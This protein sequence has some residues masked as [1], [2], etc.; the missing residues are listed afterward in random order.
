MKT[1]ESS[2]REKKKKLL[3]LLIGNERNDFIEGKKCF[4]RKDVSMENGG[5]MP[6]HTEVYVVETSSTDI[7]VIPTMLTDSQNPYDNSAW[8]KKNLLLPFTVYKEV[9][10]MLFTVK[11]REQCTPLA[12][13]GQEAKI[14]DDDYINLNDVM[15]LNADYFFEL[16]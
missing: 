16:I 9:L 13:K 15:Y 14:N 5:I 1:Q 8:V 2:S 4:L 6:H 12:T 11:L 10:E 3:S 7:R